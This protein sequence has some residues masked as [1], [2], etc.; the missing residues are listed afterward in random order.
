MNFSQWIGFIVLG[1][2]LYVMWHIKQLLLLLFTAVIIANF[3]NHGVQFLQKLGIKRGYA[4]L[5]SIILLLASLSGFF[6]IIIP[7]FAQQLPQ[8]FQLVPQGINELMSTLR[9]VALKLDP[10][11]I[12][13]LPNAQEIVKQLEPLFQRIAGQGLSVF[14]TT[15]GIPLSLLLLFALTLMLLANP[16]AY[17]QGFIRLFPSFY[18]GK[19]DRVLVE[20]D[21][22]LQGGLIA[23]LCQMMMISILTFMGLSI[24]RIP[25]TLA[26]AMLAGIL[27]FVPNFGP[28]LSV[29]PPVAIA[30]LEKPWKSVAVLILYIIIYWL[31]K[32][33]EQR[34]P[35]PL[36]MENRQALLPAF[37]LLAQV[38]FATTFGVLGF[39]LALPLA[40]VSQVWLK[41]VLI[42]DILDQ[43]QLK[44]S[45]KQPSLEGR[46][47]EAK[48]SITPTDTPS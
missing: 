18:R 42:K 40:L 41:E 43:W 4:V 26:Q 34:L 13:A 29:I 17:R 48:E 16:P 25:L 31:I 45:V 30:L 3:L 8:L 11:L 38:F 37:T 33:I 12:D 24:L 36:V 47:K 9:K 10:E 15:L 21:R 20:C 39:F 22:C 32:K 27:T 19:I 2:C 44:S 46:K 35:T 14:Y 7:P 6:W 28:I 23:V 5:L 1:L